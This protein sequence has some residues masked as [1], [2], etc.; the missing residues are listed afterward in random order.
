MSYQFKGTIR[1]ARPADAAGIC[2]IYNHYIENSTISFE[3]VAVSVEEMQSRI[4]DHKADLPWLVYCDQEKVV[5]YAYATPWR[6]RSAY[7][8]SVE[9]T[10][11]V[12][13][14]YGRRG[15]ARALYQTLIEQL[16]H[17]KLHTA[18]AGIALPNSAS[19][20]LHEAFGY[21]K[22]AE[23]KEVG[24]KFDEWVNVGYWQLAL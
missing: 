3:E 8:F 12:D 9:T 11:Y 6:A 15:I 7:R 24:M 18:I 17:A 2:S 14:E 13:K 5:A 4:R 10:V 21:E 1:S 23:F 19:I 20:G 16:R 22:V